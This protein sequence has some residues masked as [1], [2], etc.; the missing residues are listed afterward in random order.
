MLARIE[1]D[2]VVG[3]TFEERPVDVEQGRMAR[4]AMPQAVETIRA[5]RRAVEERDLTEGERGDVQRREQKAN[6]R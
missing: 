3:R 5:H 1:T 4:G 6:G 2:G